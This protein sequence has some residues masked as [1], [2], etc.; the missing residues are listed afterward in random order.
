LVTRQRETNGKTRAR[1]K[2]KNLCNQGNWPNDFV[3]CG[4]MRMGAGGWRVGAG[5]PGYRLIGEHTLRVDI[6]RLH[7]RNCLS[8]GAYSWNWHR[9]DEPAGSISIQV[10][11]ASG[12][13]LSYR[14]RDAMN[15]MWQDVAQPVHITTTP[16]RYGGTRKWFACPCCERRVEV[17]YF[18]QGRFACRY[19]QQ[20]SYASQSKCRIGRITSRLQSFEARVE[21]GKPKG[22]RW[23]TYEGICER[24]GALDAAWGQAM[25]RRFG[26]YERLL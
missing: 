25:A 16:C 1:E 19:C 24:I 26:V 15:Q 7:R 18:R 21:R 13:I 2:L 5:R 8:P 10:H 4:A 14:V 3:F 12:L 9:G 17:L 11:H 6:R 23:R 20:V 22:M